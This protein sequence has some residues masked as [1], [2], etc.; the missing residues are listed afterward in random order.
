[1]NEEISSVIDVLCERLGTSASYIIPEISKIHII[2]CVVWIVISLIIG[3]IVVT[4]MP[5]TWRY[6]RNNHGES[7]WSVI[8]IA[9]GIIVFLILIV[10]VI[11]LTGWIVSPT[12]KTIVYLFHNVGK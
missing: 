4:V 1:M 3:I 10:S 7:C 11:D 6:D 8:P 2:E 9:T 12:A 5:K